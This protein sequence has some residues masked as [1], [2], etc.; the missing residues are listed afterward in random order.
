MKRVQMP[1]F[2]LWALTSGGCGTYTTA[3]PAR[4][5]KAYVMVDGPLHQ[6]MYYC[7]ASDGTPTCRELIEK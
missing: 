7:D 5:G 4:D 2:V 6:T 1:F 3:V